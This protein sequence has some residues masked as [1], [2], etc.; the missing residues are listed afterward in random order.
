MQRTLLLSSVFLL[1]DAQQFGEVPAVPRGGGGHEE[2]LE[3]KL[4]PEELDPALILHRLP[5]PSNGEQGSEGVGLGKDDAEPVRLLPRDEIRIPHCLADRV[6]QRRQRS[7]DNA[8]PRLLHQE[9]EVL[10]DEEYDRERPVESARLVSLLLEIV[11]EE[12]RGV[13]AGLRIA[14]GNL[15]DP[16]EAIYRVQGAGGVIGDDPGHMDLTVAGR[17]PVVPLPKLHEADRG[18]LVQERNE[19]VRPAANTLLPPRCD[20]K[21]VSLPDLLR[22]IRAR[23]E[24]SGAL[25]VDPD[26]A[27]HGSDQH[28]VRIGGRNEPDD[29]VRRPE[30]ADKRL[31]NLGQQLLLVL[32]GHHFEALLVHGCHRVVFEA[33]LE[34]AVGYRA[35]RAAVGAGT[36]NDPS[37]HL[38]H[39]RFIAIQEQGASVPFCVGQ[40]A[41][42]SVPR[43]LYRSDDGGV[44]GE[45]ECLEV[46][47]HGVAE[48][49]FDGMIK[50]V[51]PQFPAVGGP[52]LQDQYPGS[53]HRCREPYIL[54]LLNC[55]GSIFSSSSVHLSFSPPSDAAAAG[56][57]D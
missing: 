15:L 18:S 48:V 8:L 7:N 47:L 52:I 38:V 23:K 27:A 34:E 26:H 3:K 14:Q 50:E 35:I 28:L 54:Y 49:E 20:K 12:R 22:R 5:E 9:G 45:V 57:E 43:G 53:F 24:E 55:S 10:D 40:D 42:K 51:E 2:W 56:M 41:D 16:P 46:L 6:D 19:E 13:G 37:R 17:L 1:G 29:A 33:F 44:E 32:R 36:Q 30:G 21:R 4:R 25:P 11:G 31:R 39:R